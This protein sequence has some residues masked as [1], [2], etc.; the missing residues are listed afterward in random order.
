[1]PYLMQTLKGEAAKKKAAMS[2]PW[3]PCM[4]DIA[5]RIHRL[6]LH[7]SMIAE[8]GR[9]WTEWRAYDDGGTFIKARR[10]DGY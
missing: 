4:A 2:S 9:D 5:H 8:A 7:G 10:V 1:M 6:E 3:D